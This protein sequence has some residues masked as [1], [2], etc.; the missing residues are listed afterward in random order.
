MVACSGKIVLAYQFSGNLLQGIRVFFKVFAGV[1]VMASTSF[2]RW[3]V[4]AGILV[5]LGGAALA[6]YY[7]AKPPATVDFASGNGRIEATE[8]LISTKLAGR[9]ATV[10]AKEG[11]DVSL[12][13]VLAQMDVTVLKANLREAQAAIGQATSRKAVA[14]A[15]VDQ[16]QS[17][18]TA[19]QALVAQRISQLELSAKEEKRTRQLYKGDFITGEKMDVDRTTTETSNAQVLAAKAQLEGA[20]AALEAARAGVLEAQAA[21][22]A[23]MAQA[24]RYEA[25]IEDSTL[26][27]PISGRVLYRLAEPGE[28]LGVGGHVLTLLDLSDV[29]LTLFLPTSQAG[30]IALGAQA[31][32]VLDVRPDV[33]IPAQVTFV[34]PQAQFTPKAV[35]THSERE[36]L[37]FRIKV[38]IPPDLLLAYAKQVKTGLPGV[39]TVRL[40]PEAPW[41]ANMPPLVG[42]KKKGQ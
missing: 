19:A 42:E 33:S 37:M 12:G 34:S 35:E 5:C 18:I 1:K 23:A 31:R 22:E 20:Q 24:A 10:L 4:G 21:I 9:L 26:T 38:T 27:A 39:A 32:I 41:P 30:R 16:R 29:Y 2:T 3:V 8:V 7:Y 40:A 25:D 6:W 11:D 17:E 14:L 36:K 13:Q 28:V 15:A